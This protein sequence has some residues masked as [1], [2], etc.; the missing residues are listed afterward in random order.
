MAAAITE[1]KTPGGIPVEH[2]HP[3]PGKPVKPTCEDCQHRPQ[4]GDGVDHLCAP[5]RIKASRARFGEMKW[6]PLP[7]EEQDDMAQG[8]MPGMGIEH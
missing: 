2:H 7:G 4:R 3:V 1:A 5:C 6:P 8:I